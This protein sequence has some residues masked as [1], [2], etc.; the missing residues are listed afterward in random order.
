MV[1]EHKSILVQAVN[2]FNILLESGYSKEI[3]LT[4]LSNEPLEKWRKAAI[5]LVFEKKCI[6]EIIE[7]YNCIVASIFVK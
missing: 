6:A 3:A 7:I 1:K 2:A 4:L 5:R